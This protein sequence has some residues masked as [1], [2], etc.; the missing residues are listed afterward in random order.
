[1]FSVASVFW[2]EYVAHFLTAIACSHHCKTSVACPQRMSY[3]ES[4]CLLAVDIYCPPFDLPSR[5][6]ALLPCRLAFISPPANLCA[7]FTIDIRVA[8]NQFSSQ[9]PIYFCNTWCNS[10]K[11]STSKGLRKVS[12]GVALGSAHV[13]IYVHFF[14]SNLENLFCWYSTNFRVGRGLRQL[15]V[16]SGS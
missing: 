8:T 16:P 9:F 12:P 14:T 5:L 11:V 15:V 7:L 10:N 13:D 6:A 3:V 1:M 2:V 4:S